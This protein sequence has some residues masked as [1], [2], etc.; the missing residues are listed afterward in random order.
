M[1]PDDDG[2]RILVDTAAMMQ[3]GDDIQKAIT[4]MYRELDELDAAAAPLVASWEGQAKEAYIVRQRQ[5][6][7]AADDLT[8]SLESI[9]RALLDSA[10]GYSSTEVS[11]T[12]LFR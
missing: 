10:D 6:R 8:Q 11:N 7:G 3:A 12:N 1:R 2:G 4:E 5:W 9:R